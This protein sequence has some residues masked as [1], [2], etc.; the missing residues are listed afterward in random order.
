[1]NAGLNYVMHGQL[2]KG[3]Q[4]MEQALKMGGFKRPEDAKLH[5]GLAQVL[6]SQ[7]SKGVETLRTVKGNDGTAELA[8]LWVLY[9]Q[10]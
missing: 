10:R 3:L 6:A 4:M 8:R 1:M 2:E 9:A 7:K 5:F